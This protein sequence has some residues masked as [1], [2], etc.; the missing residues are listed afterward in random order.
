MLYVRFLPVDA[1]L[2]MDVLSASVYVCRIAHPPVSSR[3]VSRISSYSK[4]F[5]WILSIEYIVGEKVCERTV[6]PLWAI[7]RHGR[8]FAML[9]IA[10]SR[11]GA[12]RNTKG[13][14][15]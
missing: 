11:F 2:S 8:P 9:G 3:I 1:I 14:R 6:M 4:S 5:N 7:V 13:L 10:V 15:S 12:V